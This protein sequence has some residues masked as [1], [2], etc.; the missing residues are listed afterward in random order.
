MSGSQEETMTAPAGASAATVPAP[1]AGPAATEPAPAGGPASVP[2]PRFPRFERL[3]WRPASSAKGHRPVQQLDHYTRATLSRYVWAFFAGWVLPGVLG[4]FT[5][6]DGADLVLRSALLLASLALC[7]AT[8][9]ALL[10]ALDRY[11]GR[12]DT[13]AGPA[14]VL[15]ALTA[16]TSALAL[17]CLGT[18]AINTA[19]FAPAM[20]FV[21][22]P[23][24]AVLALRVPVPRYLLALVGATVLLSAAAVLA[25]P[26][27]TPSG[28]VAVLVPVSALLALLICRPSGWSLARTW[29]IEYARQEIE[30]AKEKVERA[31]ETESR[32]AVAE[33]RLRFG[34]DLHDVLG[35]NLATIALKSE[36]AVQLARRERT[37]DA[38][39]QMAEVQEIAQRSQREVREVVRGYR[40]IDLGAE[41]LGARSVLEAAGIDCAT[42]AGDIEPLAPPV[43][44][45]LAWVV[46]E[47][48][49]NVL[50]HGDAR[51]CSIT[52][53]TSRTGTSLTV[54][55]DGAPE[56]PSPTRGGSGLAGLRERLAPVG[57][58]LEAGPTAPGRFR[59]AAH[60]PHPPATGPA[61]QTAPTPT[62]DPG[63]SRP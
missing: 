53:A 1:S 5:Q 46:R 22:S 23:V 40:G 52:L 30:K 18:D 54:E 50:R 42:A 41:L 27:G 6:G 10:D 55:N 11:L 25:D 39:A 59:L 24:F 45:A 2:G 31:K 12:G 3:S 60:V 28:V 13:R 29:D 4:H 9:P 26:E 21:V 34:R 56:S 32:L 49:T 47:A 62:P 58:A 61:P 19:T 7:A 8:R 16:L 63:G 20:M 14:W 51:H 37:E 44:A 17:L 35:R 33:E 43:Q 15:L 38:V 48:A 57:G 36:L